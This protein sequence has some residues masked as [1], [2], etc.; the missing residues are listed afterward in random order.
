[1]RLVLGGWGKAP[2]VAM[3]GNEPSGVE[4]AARNAAHEAADEW[5]SAEYRS[6]V[7]AVLA[8]RCLE[9]WEDKT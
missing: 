5:A 3:D 4:A 6:D 9:K 2:S 8:K 7:A 1:M